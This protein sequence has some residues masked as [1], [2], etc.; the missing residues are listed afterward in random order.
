MEEFPELLF[1]VMPVYDR[2][3]LRDVN[4]HVCCPFLSLSHDFI[5][6]IESSNLVQTVNGATASVRILNSSS[7]SQFCE[8]FIIASSSGP[9][10]PS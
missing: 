5:N 1:N 7:A 3:L 2:V 4:T 9:S 10:E 8:A 6:H